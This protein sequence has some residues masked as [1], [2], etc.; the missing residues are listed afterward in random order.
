LSKIP[1]SWISKE[2]PSR[3]LKEVREDGAVHLLQKKT[4]ADL[5]Q[6]Y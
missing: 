2:A 3:I 4:V 1:P 5:S 6:Q